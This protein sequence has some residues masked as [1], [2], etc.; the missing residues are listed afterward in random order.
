VVY[1]L[2][3]PRHCSAILRLNRAIVF[4]LYASLMRILHV[5]Q[6]VEAPPDW[7]ERIDAGGRPVVIDLGAGDGRYAYEC[8]RADPVSLYVAVDPAAETLAE[9][10][11]RASRKPARGGVENAVFVVAAIASLPPELQ[12]IGGRVRVNFPW[13]SLLRGLLQPDRDILA[14]VASLLKPDGVLE[15]VMSYD[16]EHDPNAFAG[17]PLPALDAGYLEATLLPAYAAAG[18]D[19]IEHRRLTRDEALALPSTWGRRLLHARPRDVYY[20]ACVPTQER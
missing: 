6:P 18:L 13:G 9:Y 1:V 12:A 5:K 8:A 20:I 4:A 14:S 2:I 19:C 15:I 7:R 10:A 11:F 3:R 17:G 16:P